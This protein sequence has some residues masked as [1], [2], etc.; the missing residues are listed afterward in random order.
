MTEILRFPG[1]G[2]PSADVHEQRFA[3]SFDYPVVFTRDVFALENR[4]LLDILDRRREGRRHR[5]AVCIDSGVAAAQ[6]ALVSRIKAYFHAH[7]ASIELAGAPEI[8]PGGEA[9]KEDWTAVKELMVAFGNLHLDRQSFV[10]VIGGGSVLDMVGF[11]TALVH[12][13]LRLVRLPTTVLAQNDAGVGVKNGMNEHGVKNFLG[14]FAPPF[15]VIDDF[16]FLATLPHEHWLGGVA[17][18]FKVAI[19]KDRAFFEFLAREAAA[20]RGRHLGAM[21][22]LI[23]RAAVLHLEH[24]AGNGDPFELG[25]ARPLDFGHWSA[26]KLEAMSGFRISHGFAVGAGVALDSFYAA[27]KGLLTSVEL[28]RILGAISTCGLR[29]WFPEMDERNASG[30]RVLLAGLEEFREHLGGRLTITLPDGIG[31]KLEVHHLD[32]GDLEDGFS[33]LRAREERAQSAR[34]VG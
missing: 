29:L 2:P 33:L 13:G 28:E 8:V 22:E 31:S 17:E 21:E 19:I 5:V 9:C 16:T 11:A 18:A 15:A 27:Q 26:H 34:T 7:Q 3:V 24:I 25:T 14:T 1:S 6:P 32:I 10:L 4:Q 30:E 12:R 20:I 23:R